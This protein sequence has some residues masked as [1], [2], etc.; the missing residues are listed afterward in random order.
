MAQA[1]EKFE[2]SVKDKGLEIG[3]RN[4]TEDRIEK[5]INRVLKNESI[6]VESQRTEVYTFSIPW[7]L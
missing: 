7:D 1:A 6:S 3:T 4:L 5:V 2:D